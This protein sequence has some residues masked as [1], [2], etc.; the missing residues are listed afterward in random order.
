M[1][2]VYYFISLKGLINHSYAQS[3]FKY[4]IQWKCFFIESNL[5]NQSET[6]F[7]YACACNCLIKKWSIYFFIGSQLFFIFQNC[8]PFIQQ[9]GCSGIHLDWAETQSLQWVVSKTEQSEKSLQK[10]IFGMY[11]SQEQLFSRKW[12]TMK[13]KVEQT[14]WIAIQSNHNSV[15]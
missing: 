1:Y 12:N 9:T 8:L 14:F 3:F 6:M 4:F 11:V 13:Q 5:I 15:Q 7:L 2:I 10:L